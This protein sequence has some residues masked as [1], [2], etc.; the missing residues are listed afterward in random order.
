MGHE[1]QLPPPR[2][3]GRRQFGEATFAGI[4]GKEEDPPKAAARVEA[5]RRDRSEI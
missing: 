5:V 3:S 4:S 1:D 2:L